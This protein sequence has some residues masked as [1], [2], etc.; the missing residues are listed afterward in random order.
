LH[1]FVRGRVMQDLYIYMQLHQ[2]AL[3]SSS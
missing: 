1:Y 3:L 2:I